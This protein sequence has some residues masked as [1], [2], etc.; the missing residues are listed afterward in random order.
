MA[1][2][3]FTSAAKESSSSA[4]ANLFWAGLYGADDAREAKTD[5]LYGIGTLNSALDNLEAC[6][7]LL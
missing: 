6:I 5:T 1:M 7:D 2:V 4:W 3:L